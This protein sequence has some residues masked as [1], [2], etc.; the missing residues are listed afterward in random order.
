[1]AVTIC[2]AL[3]SNVAG[4]W[5][6]PTAA[7]RVALETLAVRGIILHKS[8][9]TYA[10]RPIGSS[11]QPAYSNMV[12]LGTTTLTASNLLRF[13]KSLERAAGRRLGPRWSA[14]PLDIDIIDYGGRV[15]GWP[16]HGLRRPRLMLPHPEAHRRGFVLVPL[17]EIAP[18]WRHPALGMSAIQMLRR[19]PALGRGVSRVTC[20]AARRT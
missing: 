12:V 1:M 3:G 19:N 16:P 8:S 17:A 11:R 6:D 5:G 13:A 10:T 4:H 2:L 9:S 15:L 7:L 14:R 20:I 18:H